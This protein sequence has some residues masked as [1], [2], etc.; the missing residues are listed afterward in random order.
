MFVNSVLK[1]FV[2]ACGVTFSLTVLYLLIKKKISEWSV[3]TWL[4]GVVVILLISANPEWV[5]KLARAV[6]I[7]YPPSLLFLFSTLILLVL[8]LYQSIQIS[9]LQNK[10][11]QIAQHVALQPHLKN[12][13]VQQGEPQYALGLAETAATAEEAHLPKGEEGSSDAKTQR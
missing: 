12:G 2:L 9:S 5:D 1:L 11:R 4:T 6:G 13:T 10:V 7:S 8:V 3:I